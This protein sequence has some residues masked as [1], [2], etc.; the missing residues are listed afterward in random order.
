MNW[1]KYKLQIIGVII[2]LITL[3]WSPW[4]TKDYAEKEV[5]E[6]YNA[7]ANFRAI[8]GC[9]FN[10]KNCGVYESNKVL[11]GYEVVVLYSCG[12]KDYPPIGIPDWQDRVFISFLGTAHTLSHESNLD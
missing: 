4:I 3:A 1:R 10:C 9:G 12:M 6:N 5:I 7:R 11:F 8:D 2:F